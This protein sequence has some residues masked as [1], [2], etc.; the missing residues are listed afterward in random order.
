MQVKHFQKMTSG[1]TLKY[2]T[3]CLFNMHADDA[4][5]AVGT[6]TAM[7]GREL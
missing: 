7:G 4:A 6:Q 1:L 3:A 2:P 5:L